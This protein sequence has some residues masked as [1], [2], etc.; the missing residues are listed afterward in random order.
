MQAP[1]AV[2]ES[3]VPTGTTPLS[4]PPHVPQAPPDILPALRYGRARGSKPSSQAATSHPFS[5]FFLSVSNHEASFPRKAPEEPGSPRPGAA[6][7]AQALVPTP[8]L[9]PV[10]APAPRRVQHPAPNPTL[11]KLRGLLTCVGDGE[12]F[13]YQRAAQ[14][15]P[16][17]RMP[18]CS[19]PRRQK[20]LCLFCCCCC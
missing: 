14:A 7:S 5:L 1:V 19:Y 13:R 20:N 2:P 3:G 4:L 18:H 12:V 16:P 15:S 17:P 6:G 10:P 11:G 8:A 9:V